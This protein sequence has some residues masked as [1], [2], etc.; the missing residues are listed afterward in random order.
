M[1]ISHGI[2]QAIRNDVRDIARRAYVSKQGDLALSSWH[3][4]DEI[5]TKYKSIFVTI[6]I[7]VL[8]RLAIDF[9]NYWIDQNI[10]QPTLAHR[11]GEPDLP[12]EDSV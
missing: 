3:A 10:K 6:L 4:E 2:R 9:I 7:G 8:I 12:F 11:S 5:R 1:T